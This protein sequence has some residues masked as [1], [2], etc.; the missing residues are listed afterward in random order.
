MDA[1]PG[2]NNRIDQ[3][4]HATA[5]LGF[6]YR[7][8]GAPLTLGGNLNWTPGYDTQLTI[9]QAQTLSTKRVFDAY[10]LWTVSPSTKIRLSVSNIA[11]QDSLS[12][13]TVI[14]AGLR[15]V[16]VSNGRTDMSVLLRLEMRL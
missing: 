5:N 11:P 4:P 8:P 1:V 12:S 13:N 6:D 16:V 9:T 14:D 3:Q 10:A 2:P 15:Q 7:V